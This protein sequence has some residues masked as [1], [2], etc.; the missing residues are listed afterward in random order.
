MT[1]AALARVAAKAPTP[2][3]SFPPLASAWQ[4]PRPSGWAAPEQAASAPAGGV[5]GHDFGRLPAASPRGAGGDRPDA[6][7]ATA[8][9]AGIATAPDAGIATAPDAGT[10][11][12]PPSPDA[13][14]PP[15]A[16]P[17]APAVPA[18]SW[19]HV[20][21]HRY[22][23][24]WWFCGEKPSGFSVVANLH[25][26][27]FT[28][29][30]ALTWKVTRGADKVAFQ[31]AAAGADA[32]VASK[33]GSVKADDVSIEVQEG[34]GPG[35]PTY[36]GTLTVRKPHR[37]VMG[38]IVDHPNCPVW[39][40]C[41]LACTAFWTEI[42]YRVLDNV[43]GTIVGATVNENFPGGIV[44]DQPNN[45]PT[46]AAFATVPF[47]SQTR[48]TFV[49]NWFVSCRNPSPVAPGNPA[50]G[51]GVDRIPHEFFVGSTT[52]GKGCRV[53]THTAHRY[54]GRTRH[55]GV[56]SPAP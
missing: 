19:T 38:V 40:G 6:G 35:A 52:P 50:A 41:P 44:A 5:P 15:G 42:P 23:A 48:G 7:I 24:L 34:T 16:P 17:A 9:D 18:L 30:A 53:Q 11:P 3:A 43:G 45:W 55:E 47:W 46:P 49:D 29:A 2:P 32:T 54:R 22:D 39:G 33:A 56:V 13:G 12:A 27:G 25:A 20:L 37:L 26:S 14:T 1:A 4:R 21:A 31:G 51:Q 10:L 36:T 28:N 8:P